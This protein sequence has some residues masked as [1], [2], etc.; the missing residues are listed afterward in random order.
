LATINSKIF[1]I[2]SIVFLSAISI[3]TACSDDTNEAFSLTDE[4]S[5]PINTSET[6][7]TIDAGFQ[8]A[9]TFSNFI[10]ETTTSSST[11]TTQTNSSTPTASIRTINPVI[12]KPVQPKPNPSPQPV[13]PNPQPAVPTP[14][15]PAFQKPTA[16][17]IQSQ[18]GGGYT[19]L[20]TK[21]KKPTNSTAVK[22]NTTCKGYSGGLYLSL[23]KIICVSNG[24]DIRAETHEVVHA[25][26]DDLYTVDQLSTAFGRTRA[27]D[28]FIYGS[29]SAEM[30]AECVTKEL[31]LGN[32][33]YVTSGALNMSG[34]NTS[35]ARTVINNIV[36]RMR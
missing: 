2:I 23:Y 26:H 22:A 18:I 5:S 32:S 13:T 19:S 1:R 17:Q 7:T 12:P 6:S 11:S 31:G 25:W 9:S 24:V 30:T 16:A 33:S 14:Q 21:Y 36:S 3:S 28:T 35:S 10:E 8:S 4:D 20:I 34:C 15:S 29:Y 27:N